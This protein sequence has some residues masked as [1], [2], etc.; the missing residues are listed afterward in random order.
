MHRYIAVPCRRRILVLFLRITSR[1][2][3]CSYMYIDVALPHALLCIVIIISCHCTL[4][5]SSD[6][7]D[8]CFLSKCLDKFAIRNKAI[9]TMQSVNC[10]EIHSS[11]LQTNAAYKVSA[12]QLITEWMIENSTTFMAMY[13]TTVI[14]TSVF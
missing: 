9:V 12:K 7:A 2:A 10:E 5:L 8:I 3:S 13:V 4:S 14:Q 6:K 1:V 11:R